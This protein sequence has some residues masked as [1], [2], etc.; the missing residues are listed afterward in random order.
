MDTVA[1]YTESPHQCVNDPQANNLS[2]NPKYWEFWGRCGRVGESDIVL[3]ACGRNL[4]PTCNP[5]IYWFVS[6]PDCPWQDI[7]LKGR[8]YFTTCLF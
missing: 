5:L 8:S 6:S 3:P 7:I 4:P 2:K 1:S